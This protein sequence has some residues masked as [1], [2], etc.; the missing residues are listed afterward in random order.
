MVKHARGE[1]FKA[2]KNSGLYVDVDKICI[3][4][5]YHVLFNFSQVWYDMCNVAV[6]HDIISLFFL[7]MGTYTDG[8]TPVY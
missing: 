8:L 2:L 7:Y 4:V 6:M 1:F 5:S 3:V